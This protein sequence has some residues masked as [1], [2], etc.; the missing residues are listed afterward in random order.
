MQRVLLVHAFVLVVCGAV[1]SP[2]VEPSEL[3]GTW[4]EIVPERPRIGYS[5]PREPITLI[6]HGSVLVEK[7]GERVVRQSL[8]RTIPNRT[9]KAIDLMTVVEGEFWQTPAIYK[10]ESDLL[11]ICEGARDEQRPAQFRGWES[12][13][14]R[15]VLLRSFKRLTTS[16]PAVEPAARGR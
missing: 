12:I 3:D 6:V 15:L 14:D 10:I 9:P 1:P 4:I 13:D 11:A 7:S 16:A 8:F 5:L 2:A